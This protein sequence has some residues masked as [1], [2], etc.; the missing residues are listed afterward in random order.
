[1]RT[2]IG[3]ALVLLFTALLSSCKTD[4]E[5]NDNKAPTNVIYG[6]LDL[7]DSIQY[8]KVEKTFLNSAGL[9]ARAVASNID[10]VYPV[11]ATVIL[12][13]NLRGNITT[14]TLTRSKISTQPTNAFPDPTGYV[15]TTPPGTVLDKDAT[16]TISVTNNDTKASATAQTNLVGHI[17]TQYPKD[18]SKL[19]FANISGA[20]T[21]M[22]FVP[23]NNAAV[24]S[25]LI[26]MP[27]E[28]YN[29]ADNTLLKKD[30]VNWIAYSY[31]ENTGGQ[32]NAGLA[33]QGFYNA[34]AAAV[35]VDNKVNRKVGPL[36][37]EL[38]GGGNSLYNYIL[39]NTP[40]IGLVQNRP[41][42]TNVTN[43][44]GI[45]SSRCTDR[46]HCVMN[47][48]MFITLSKQAPT[49]GLNFIQ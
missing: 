27:Y 9:T 4:F 28:E 49:A 1:M 41:N 24:Y 13:E 14:Y 6:L 5:V 17:V 46:I 25:V 43:G 21:V 26:R 29:K 39:V 12:S 31:I 11:N 34:V 33:G 47:Q 48:E 22:R 32:I 35:H 36:I 18:S 10:S 44:L 8:V 16:Y 23:G 15:Y 20:V 7:S 42:Y 37:V 45:F 19:N 2:R 30:T 3:L 38:T 40:S